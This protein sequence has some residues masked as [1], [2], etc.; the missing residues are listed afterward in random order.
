M[1]EAKHKNVTVRDFYDRYLGGDGSLPPV[2]HG[3][4]AG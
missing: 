3:I 1:F 4:L 2:D